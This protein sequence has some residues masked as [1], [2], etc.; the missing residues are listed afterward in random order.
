MNKIKQIGLIIA[1]VVLLSSCSIS[2][3][4]Q[5]YDVA[6]TSSNGA[7]T[8]ANLTVNNEDCIIDYNFWSEGGDAGFW[9]YNKT[10]QNVYIHLDES[11]FVLNGVAHNY[12]KDR[13]YCKSINTGVAVKSSSQTQKQI[14]DY[15][16][17]FSSS[18]SSL[19]SSTSTQFRKEERIV[20]IPSNTSKYIKEY[21]ITNGVYRDCN[22]LRFPKRKRVEEL[23]YTL[24]NSPFVFG[25]RISYS[26]GK[27]GEIKQI[28]NDF[29]VSK[30]QN[31][32]PKDATET[33]YDQ[34]CGEKKY[35]FKKY[36]KRGKDNQFY[37]EYT[38]KEGAYKH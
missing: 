37:I 23:S 13:V 14:A 15:N 35:T 34:Y 29:F 19:A 3:Y 8:E 12:Y 11:F 38:K 18:I 4:Y 17:I 33:L 20:C 5:F 7:E 16:S 1:A 9:F 2:S 36:I 25:N 26:V 24:D 30:I 22:L 32:H 27:T 31:K 10:D 6:S 21:T 28:S